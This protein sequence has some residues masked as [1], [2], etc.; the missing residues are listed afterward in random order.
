VLE[1]I[2]TTLKL[3]FIL[4]LF[5]K[6]S[7]RMIK[8]HFTALGIFASLVLFIIAAIQYP[9]GSQK[10]KNAVG[11]DW[12]NNY[13]CNLF[14]ENAINGQ[15]SSSRP[16]AI[17][18][19]FLLC[20]SIAVFFIRFSKRIPSIKSS[21]IIKYSGAS[22]MLFAFLVFTPYHDLMTTIASALALITL[23]YVL[24]YIMK[25]T[26]FYF[27]LL[28]IACL[29]VLYANNYIYYSHNFLY[30]LP[31]MQKI[32]FL[33]IVVWMIGLEYFSCAADFEHLK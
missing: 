21:R 14:N 30:A 2:L 29:L 24:F 17:V 31:V 33:C 26:L 10:D 4:L 3:K 13:L 1:F 27:K 28:S 5:C 6:Q 9:G 11:Y 25:S 12:K 20:L 16:W 32:S 23:S 15:I 18:G 7:I 8:K 22:A 19:M